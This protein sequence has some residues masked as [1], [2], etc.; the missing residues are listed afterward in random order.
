MNREID[1]FEKDRNLSIQSPISY[2]RWRKKKREYRASARNVFSF[3]RLMPNGIARSRLFLGV[4]E[5][6]ILSYWL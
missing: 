5:N 2:I 4:Y 6:C 1:L 3:P